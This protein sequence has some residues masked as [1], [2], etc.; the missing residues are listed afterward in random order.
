MQL[1]IQKAKHS[2]NDIEIIFDLLNN[3][4]QEFDASIIKGTEK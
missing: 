4:L 1:W 3:Q 2:R